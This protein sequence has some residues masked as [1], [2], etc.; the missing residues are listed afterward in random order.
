MGRATRTR[1]AALI[2]GGCV[3]CLASAAA[4]E[5]ARLASAARA[6]PVAPATP[7]IL[8][9]AEGPAVPGGGFELRHAAFSP[10]GRLVGVVD[11]TRTIRLLDVTDGTLVER[12]DPGTAE[13][14]SYSMAIANTGRVAVGRP[15]SMQIHDVTIGEPVAVFPCAAERCLPTALAFSPDGSLLAFHEIAP[16]T[17]QPGLGAVRVVELE[18][19]GPTTLRASTGL[20]Q[21][22]FPA[23]PADDAGAEPHAFRIWHTS[24]WELPRSMLGSGWT[25]GTVPADSAEDPEALVAV[26]RSGSNVVMRE[27]ATN[28]LLWAAPLIRPQFSAAAARAARGELEHVEVAP[29]GSFMIGYEAPAT[30]AAEAR[31]AGAIVI[32]RT[33]DGAVVEIYDVA[34]V[35]DIAIAPDSRTFAYTT[36]AGRVHTALVRVPEL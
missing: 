26:H 32:R 16:F 13:R 9:R 24:D 20:G 8:W 11:P 3:L 36:G 28:R 18:L 14:V 1:A 33:S 29:N 35:A 34:A 5:S 4:Q 19:T 6:A 17:S 31:R 23:G 22:A 21:L 27:F 15:G 30:G 12:V 25:V 7:E 2:F 10:D